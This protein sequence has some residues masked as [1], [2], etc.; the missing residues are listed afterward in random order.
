MGRGVLIAFI[1]GI[2]LAFSASTATGHHAISA[3]FDVNKP[4]E[5]TG[6]VVK[7]DWL[8]PHTYT[9]VEVTQ[10][11]GTGIVYKVEGGPPNALYRS[12][13]RKESLPIGEEVTV[14]G[15]MARNPESTNVGSARITNEAGLRFFSGTNPN[16]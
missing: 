6:K 13:W 11:D 8:N 16:Q 15:I 7:I 1:L 14:A 12:G 5:F 9:H 3:E 4:I 10:P 2:G